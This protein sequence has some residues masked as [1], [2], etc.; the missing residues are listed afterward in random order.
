VV[1]AFGIF[2]AIRLKGASHL[3]SKGDKPMPLSRWQNLP[4]LWRRMQRL[5][6]EMNRLFR[7]WGEED[8]RDVGAAFPPVNLWEEGDALYLQAEL[9]GMSLQDLEIFVTG[10]DQLTIKGERKPPQLAEGAVQHRQERGFGTFVRVLPLPFPV[11][12]NQVEARL[13]NGVLCLKLP[14]HETAKPRKIIVKA[15]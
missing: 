2:F 13:E 7:H 11:D 14:K 5:Q 3:L 4:P 8:F 15:E 1:P 6:N 10:N 12:A 9:P